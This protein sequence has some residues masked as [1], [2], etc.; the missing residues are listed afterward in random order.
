MKF[1]TG[2]KEFD[3]ISLVKGA[4]CVKRGGKIISYFVKCLGHDWFSEN[5]K[6]RK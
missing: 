2:F 5:S 6:E 4:R 3:H 1:Q